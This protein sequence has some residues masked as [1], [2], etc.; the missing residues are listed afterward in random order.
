MKDLKE[1]IKKLLL[2]PTLALSL[3]IASQANAE[4]L[5]EPS[6]EE[7]KQIKAVLEVGDIYRSTSSDQE[8][9]F[10][11]PSG[12]KIAIKH[13]DPE[14]LTKEVKVEKPKN[15]Y[16]KKSD[17]LNINNKTL[18]NIKEE[19]E[20]LQA[21][22]EDENLSLRNNALFYKPGKIAVGIN[23]EEKAFV[24][25]YENKKTKVEAKL[26]EDPSIKL[27]KTWEIK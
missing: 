19:F 11:Q 20:K 12:I 24:T 4:R 25:E 7:L 13:L 15:G 16:G 21:K 3:S 26:G 9:V 18:D 23:H 14:E 2:I 27:S 5:A 6:K 17:L 8:M 1:Q 10:E 22:M